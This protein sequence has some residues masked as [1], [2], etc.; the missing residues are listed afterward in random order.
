MSFLFDTTIQ[1]PQEPSRSRR[2]ARKAVEPVEQARPDFVPF[3]V[4]VPPLGRLDGDVACIDQSCRAQCHDIVEEHAGQWLLECCFC[5]TG[6]WIKA[7]AGHL[8]APEEDAAFRF[9]DGRFAGLTLDEAART[10]RGVDYIKWAAVEHRRGAVRE[11]AK[12][13]LASK[14]AGL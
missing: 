1:T 9:R 8:P 2:K 5:G 10:P 14:P 4:V 6:Q 3:V 12:T 7:I 11:A 13:W